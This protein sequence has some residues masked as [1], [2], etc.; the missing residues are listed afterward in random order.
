MLA[1]C[2][3]AVLVEGHRKPKSPAV[4]QRTKTGIQVI[5]ARINQFHRDHQAAEHVC[6]G[7]MRL[8]V[9]PKFV[10]A[11]EHVAAKER[12]AFAFEIKIFREPTHFVAALLHPF[13]EE[14][15][16][17]GALCVP[18]IAGDKFAANSQSGVGGENHIRKSR[19]RRNQMHLAIQF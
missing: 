17:T 10:A 19:L 13:Y 15:L 4:G 5:K 7:A 6:D 14:R 11:E 3:L 1:D 18:E 2:A 8:N 12:I 9:G 16:F